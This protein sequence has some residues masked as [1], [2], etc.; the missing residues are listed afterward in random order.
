V[1]LHAA[2]TAIVEDEGALL[3]HRVLAATPPDPRLAA[4]LDDFARREAAV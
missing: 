4:E 2:A 3:R 1:Q